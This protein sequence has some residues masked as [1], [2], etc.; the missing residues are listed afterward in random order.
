MSPQTN[1]IPIIKTKWNLEVKKQKTGAATRNRN[2]GG[3]L[4]KSG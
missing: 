1:K 2:G 3:E 4:F